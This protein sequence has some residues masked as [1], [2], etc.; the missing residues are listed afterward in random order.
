MSREP[1]HTYLKRFWRGRH[2]TCKQ[3]RDVSRRRRAARLGSM[4][5][6]NVPPMSSGTSTFST[7]D[8]SI[9]D[10]VDTT[11]VL[12]KLTKDVVIGS[13]V[14][15]KNGDQGPRG[16]SVV[17]SGYGG[18]KKGQ[19]IDCNFEDKTGAAAKGT[20][21]EKLGPSPGNPAALVTSAKILGCAGDSV[22]PSN[23]D[24][25][26]AAYGAGHIGAIKPSGKIGKS[27]GKPLVNPISVVDGACT[28]GASK[29]SY[30]A[31]YVYASD[32]TIGGVIAF[33]VNYYG[34]T[35]PPK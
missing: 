21:A 27:W 16:A 2:D 34:N 28:A 26:V 25:Y 32:A 10:N 23:D 4:Q 33:S 20:T 29:C 3:D 7:S 1:M 35:K 5:L 15:L 31:E 18:L 6:S 24:T 22:S 12:K 9:R 11:S 8:S 13:T 19:I 30:S 17:A 14:D